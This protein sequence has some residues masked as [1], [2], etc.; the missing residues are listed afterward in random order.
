MTIKDVVYLENGDFN[1]NPQRRITTIM[2]GVSEFLV[3]DV[4]L[5]V[6]DLNCEFG[7]H[8]REYP[9][10]WGFL[11]EATITL[12]DIDTKERIQYSVN[13]GS[14]L[15]IPPRVASKAYAKVG[16]A[17]VTCSPKADRVKKTHKYQFN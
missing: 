17:I 9:E 15:F 6:V 3:G 12:E 5:L 1:Q 8:W 4:R 11:G 2:D 7:G 16:T 14:R 13:N 10:V